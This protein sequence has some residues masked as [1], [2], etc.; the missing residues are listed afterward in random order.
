MHVRPAW[1]DDRELGDGTALERAGLLGLELY[2]ETSTSA[3]VSFEAAATLQKLSNGMFLEGGFAATIRA[4]PAL[5]LRVAPSVTFTDGEPRWAFAFDDDGAPV[6]GRQRAENFSVTLRA[7]WTFAPRLTLQLYSQVFLAS[8]DYHGFQRGRPGA[9]RIELDDLESAGAPASDPD[10]QAADLNLSAVLRWEWSLGAAFW[11][12][13][14][15]AQSAAPI[16][17][18]EVGPRLDAAPLRD[19]RAVDVILGKLS[20]W[21]G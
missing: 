1:F 20:W 11:L 5:D 2:L 7:T 16:L 17:D 12:V 19:G 18:P 3:P 10:F 15:R 8:V 21:W 14:S 6:L 13:Y 9:R 4:I